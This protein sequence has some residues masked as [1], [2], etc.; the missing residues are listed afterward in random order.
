MLDLVSSQFVGQ[1]LHFGINLFAALACVAAGWLYLD[2]WTE[3]HRPKE[4]AKGGGFLLLAGGFITTGATWNDPGALGVLATALELAGY[5]AVGVGELLE[6][7]Q[8]RPKIPGYTPAITFSAT[9][10]T[11]V[12]SW[13]LPFA[14][15]GVA[16][17]Y[18]QRVVVGLERHYRAP[19]VS[20]TLLAIANAFALADR[21]QTSANPLLQQLAQPL[22]LFW[23]IDHLIL[24]AAAIVLARW[25]WRYLAKRLLSQLFLTITSLTFIV[26]LIATVSVSGILLTNLQRD[27]LTSLATATKVLGY[28]IDSK[29]AETRTDA[30]VLAQNPGVVQAATARDSAALS[31]LANALL[32]QKQLS[33]AIITDEAGLVLARA[34]DPERH[35]DSLSADPLVQHALAGTTTSSIASHSGALSPTLVTTTATPIRIGDQIIGLALASVA[36]D[37]AFVDGI[38]HTTGLD[39]TVYSG[40]TRAA[41]TLTQADGVSRAIGT[42]EAHLQITTQV[43]KQDQIWQGVTDISNQSFLA[44]YLPLKDVDNS[45][46][47][48]LFVGQP[49]DVG[50]QSA[51][52]AIKLTFASAAILLLSIMLPVYFIAR[53][54]SRQLH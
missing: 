15:L 12:L 45:V 13:C 36:L 32:V 1:S 42:K 28:A 44:V 4:L 10:V 20:F 5:I 33:E 37:N 2:A 29:T 39:S 7:I 9:G 54:I 30:E 47:G 53:G 27:S 48:M 25:V 16:A 3:R 35:G 51:R 43:L 18:W 11:G 34:S 8:A 52:Q 6:P 41:T 21:W 19:A 24:A 26:V 31:T 46:I 17:L 40:S 22:G 49:Q 14:A 50:L 23:V 38:K